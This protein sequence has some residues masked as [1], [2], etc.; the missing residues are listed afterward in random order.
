MANHAPLVP[1]DQSDAGRG[2]RVFISH[3]TKDRKVAEAI[4]AA[5][6]SARIPCWIAP[7]DIEP[8]KDWASEIMNGLGACSLMVLVVSGSAQESADVARELERA[9]GRKIPIVPFRIDDVMLT[10]AFEY[11]LAKVHWLDAQSGPLEGHLGELTE[12]VRRAIAGAH[13]GSVGRLGRAR[14]VVGRAAATW[15]GISPLLA[16]VRLKWVG[17]GALVLA[18]VILHQI[19]RPMEVTLHA[20]TERISFSLVGTDKTITV[21][22]GLPLTSLTLRG[23]P[24]L[25]RLAVKEVREAGKTLVP[26]G[27]EATL[28]AQGPEASLTMRSVDVFRL[29]HLMLGP[30]TRLTLYADR[31]GH[32]ILEAPP[33]SGKPDSAGCPRQG[34]PGDQGFGLG[35]QAWGE[36]RVRRPRGRLSD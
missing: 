20:T 35:G 14:T 18:A 15:A 25:R 23:P 9:A 16:R 30:R 19:P 22:R 1:G 21:L 36:D 17:V 13:R 33:G 28:E 34:V 10:Q 32:V 24:E 27:G 29:E 5:L 3:S 12:V 8:G 2:G 26:S 6:E 7:R 31:E 11:F 4:C